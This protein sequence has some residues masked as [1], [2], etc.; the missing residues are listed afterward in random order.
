MCDLL[1]IILAV[2]LVYIVVAQPHYPP[3]KW[4]NNAHTYIPTYI[5]ESSKYVAVCVNA[6]LGIIV[7]QNL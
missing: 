7:C 6:T 2:V 3:T 4:N 5:Y 1:L